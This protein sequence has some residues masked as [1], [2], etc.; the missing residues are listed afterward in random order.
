MTSPSFEKFDY[1]LRS[2]KNIERKLIFDLLARGRSEFGFKD[3]RYIGLGSMWF[4]DHRLAHRLLGIDDL[5]SI[6]RKE[7]VGRAEYNK[8]YASVDVIGGEVDIVFLDHPNSFSAKSVVC[9]L[10]YDGTLTE[11][12]AL[13]LERAVNILAEDSVLIVTV[14]ASRRAYRSRSAQDQRAL[15]R[16]EQVLGQVVPAGL[17]PAE[18]PGR[19]PED[20]QEV[21]FPRFL[22]ESVLSYLRHKTTVSG[23]LNSGNPLRFVPLYNL[24][25]RD[26]ADMITVGG[27]ISSTTKENSW[28]SLLTNDQVLE[29]DNGHPIHCSLDMVPI[30]L[31]EKL[32]LDSLLPLSGGNEI[33]A[34]ATAQGIALPSE[35]V[36]KYERYYRH[37]PIFIEAPL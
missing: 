10:D 14:N 32:A 18:P 21:D 26:G 4:A 24:G 7:H 33:A 37:F 5:V 12:V 1:Q 22:A 6:E 34:L 2:N 35:Q 15:A 3:Y 36:T 8:P 19:A 20:V 9:W 25:H 17:R 29:H 31:K 16:I 30:T 28:R 23:R 13:A 11:R 27:A